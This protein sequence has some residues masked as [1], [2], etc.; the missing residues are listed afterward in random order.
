MN[1]YWDFYEVG[2]GS[3]EIVFTDDAGDNDVSIELNTP[4]ILDYI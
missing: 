4:I 1:Y 3:F 2:T